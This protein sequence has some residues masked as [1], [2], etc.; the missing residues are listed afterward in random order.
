[1][2]Y[3]E[4]QP[5]YHVTF[6]SRLKSVLSQGLVVG[7]RRVWKNSFGSSIGEKQKIHLFGDLD[8]A[9]KWAHKMEYDFEKPVAILKCFITGQIEPD[10]NIQAQMTGKA[11]TT[12]ESIPADKIIGLVYPD[13]ALYRQI[14][15]GGK[16]IEPPTWLSP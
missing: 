16:I 15:N 1:M 13:V 9:V 10:T 7:K 4:I 8:G 12:D 14:V 5:Y 3:S 6:K 2:K 11:V